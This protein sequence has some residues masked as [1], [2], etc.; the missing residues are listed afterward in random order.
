MSLIKAGY[1][2]YSEAMSLTMDEIEELYEYASKYE[3][4]MNEEMKKALKKG[5]NPWL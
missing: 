5:G 2:T 4:D 1:L 3:K